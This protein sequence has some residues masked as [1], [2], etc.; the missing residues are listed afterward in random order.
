MTDDVDAL[1]ERIAQLE[2]E[3]EAMRVHGA[4]PAPPAGARSGRTASRRT[5]LGIGAGLA[6]AALIRGAP[7]AADNGD[8]LFAGEVNEQTQTTELKLPAQ[9]PAGQGPR[10][11][12]FTAQ[13]GA[14]IGQTPNAS[15]TAETGTRAAIAGYAGNDALHGIWGQTN[16]AVAGS[17][18]GRFLGESAVAYGIDV[19]GRRATMRL[20][21]PNGENSPPPA[22]FDLHNE[23]EVTFDDAGDLWFCVETGSPGTWRRLSG[24]GTAGAMV[25]IAPVRVLDSRIQGVPSAGRID[26]GSSRLVSVAHGYDENGERTVT[27]A[28][29][30]G[31]TAVV[32]NV[33]AVRHTRRNYLSVV[34][35][36]VTTSTTSTVNWPDGGQPVANGTTVG[37]DANRLVNVVVGPS[38]STDVLIDVT[39]YYR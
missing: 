14:W 13:D 34:P 23:G 6:G 33:T 38:G 36:D 7:V 4:S 28:V 39:A 21:R 8:S 24:P 26:P 5:A 27:D 18:G 25:P 19:A 31:A 32:I 22:R 15:Q 16:T 12:V 9:I 1:A 29:P 37:V 20:R 35:G 11:H 17:C 10:S 30:R 3:L 2:A